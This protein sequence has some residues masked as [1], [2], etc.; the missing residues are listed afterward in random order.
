MSRWPWRPAGLGWE[1]W[2]RQAGLAGPA[3]CVGAALQI[4]YKKG[5]RGPHHISGHKFSAVMGSTPSG[6]D[7]AHRKTNKNSSLCFLSILLKQG[8]F[9]PP[10]RLVLF[11]TSRDRVPFGDW[12]QELNNKARAKGR[13]RLELL[14]QASRQGSSK[15]NRL[16]LAPTAA[17][18]L[19][20][21]N[22]AFE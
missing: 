4:L 9:M 6:Q 20:P 18:A 16:G 17:F 21:E 10:V 1:G 2:P 19:D 7:L 13:I 15:G 22:H 11:R 12:F 14:S 8:K 5:P 3:S